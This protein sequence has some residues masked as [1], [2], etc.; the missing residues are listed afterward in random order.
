[1]NMKKNIIRHIDRQ[2]YELQSKD[3]RLE[4]WENLQ[5]I[6]I[7]YIKQSLGLDSTLIYIVKKKNL[8]EEV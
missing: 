1:M 6:Q 5:K 3:I 2:H 8:E 7:E 4:K